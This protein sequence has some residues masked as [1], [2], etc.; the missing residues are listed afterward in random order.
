MCMYQILNLKLLQVLTIF[1]T[2][3]TI[4]NHI[5]YRYAMYTAESADN[6]WGPQIYYHTK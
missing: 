5:S 2:I 3:L 1:L 4:F 6:S